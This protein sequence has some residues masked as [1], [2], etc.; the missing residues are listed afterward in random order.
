MFLLDGFGDAL[1]GEDS[2]SV[3]LCV[4]KL[5]YRQFERLGVRRTPQSAQDQFS[6][7]ILPGAL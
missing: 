4:I 3:D 6:V 1:D 2:F 5:R 7:G